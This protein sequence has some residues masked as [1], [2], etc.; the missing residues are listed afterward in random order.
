MSG[1][2]DY[3]NHDG[4]GLAALVRDG[5]V[6]PRDLLESAIAAA[7]TINREIRQAC[8]NSQSD[9]FCQF[10]KRVRDFKLQA[11]FFAQINST[12]TSLRTAHS[13]PVT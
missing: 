2:R 13:L 6:T 8:L 5:D 11:A 7:E 9:Q 12:D 10:C 1:F 4:L 3:R